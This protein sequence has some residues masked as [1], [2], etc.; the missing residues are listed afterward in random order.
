MLFRSPDIITSAKGLTS[1]YQPLS[2]TLLTE[3]IFDVISGEGGMFMHGMTYS[4][5]PAAC[6]AGLANIAIME[7]EDL[8]GRVRKYGPKFERALHRLDDLDVV[9]EV[10]GSHFMQGIEFVRDKKTRELF[11][12]EANI[13]GRVAK[14]AQ[15]RGLI[16]RPL[17]HMAILSPPLTLGDTEIAFVEE[18]LG[19]AIRASMDDLVR[20]GLL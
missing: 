8:C 18:T 11:S 14:H 1:G 13:G 16:V 19:A 5:H 17:G 4:G 10:R 12:Q 9:G 7:R 15:K 3:E 20:E 6:A 2:G